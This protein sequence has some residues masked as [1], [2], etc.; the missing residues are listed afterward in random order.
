MTEEQAMVYPWEVLK[1]LPNG[2]Y[3]VRIQ[4]LNFEVQ[5]YKWG[6]MKKFR[7]NLLP[8]DWVDVEVNEYD[9]TKWRIIYRH[10]GNPY[11]QANEQPTNASQSNRGPQ[12]W[13][14]KT[15]HSYG[16]KR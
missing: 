16:K 2:H 13:N 9:I 7:I 8:G 15:R 11:L 6:K 4:E 10:K 12:R 5:A 14:Q 3:K 1:L